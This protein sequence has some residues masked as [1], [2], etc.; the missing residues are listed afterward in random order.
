VDPK[1][2]ALRSVFAKKPEKALYTAVILDDPT[3]LLTL[4]ER[5]VGV[6]LHPK[7]IAHHMTIK[8]K[9][10]PEEVTKLP[11]GKRVNLRVIGYAADDKGQAV[12]VVPQGVS[13]TKE[14]PHVTVAVN[15]TS[16]AYSNEL[17]KRGWKPLSGTLRG[18][19]GYQGT[20]G[21][22]VFDLAGT[23]YDGESA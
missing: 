1:R 8:F 17:L 10:S 22:E 23:I 6:P 3:D 16:P 14:V 13:S 19:V 18:R 5:E 4:W 21:N 20:K 9:P 11:I 2:A 7:K 15:G 12:V